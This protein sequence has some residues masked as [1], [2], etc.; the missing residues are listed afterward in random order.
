MELDPRLVTAALVVF[1]IAM[2]LIELYTHRE[3]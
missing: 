1:L 2:Y 3:K